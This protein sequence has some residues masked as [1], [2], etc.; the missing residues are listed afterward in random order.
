LVFFKQKKTRGRL[1]R[2]LAKGQTRLAYLA[3]AIGL[4]E[5]GPEFSAKNFWLKIFSLGG[6]A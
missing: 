1:G 4:F 6:K 2:P 5:K 3:A